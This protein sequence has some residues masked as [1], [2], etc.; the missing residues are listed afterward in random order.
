MQKK[1]LVVCQ[2]Y[3][4]ENFRI[5]D[6]I[7]GFTERGYSVDV[8]CG[9]PN[10]PT[11]QFFPGYDSHSIKEEMHNGVKVYRTFEIKRG[12]NSNIRIFLNY[13][14]FPVA[15]LLRSGKLKKNNYDKIFIYELSPVMM[16][17]AGLSLGRKMGIETTMYVLDI[18]PQNLYSVIDFKSTF[19]RKM[20]YKNS[21]WHYRK[22]DRLITVS[23]TAK[24]YFIEKLNLDE[25]RVTYIP[26]CPEKIYEEEIMDPDLV[27]KF[28]GGFNIIFAG[29]LSPAQSL[30]TI[31]DV[32][33]MVKNSPMKDVRFI[34]VGDGMSTQ[35][36]RKNVEEAGL[37]DIFF[38]EGFHPIEDIPKYTYIADALLGT[39]KVNGLQ[40]YSIPAKVMSYLAAGRPILLSMGGEAKK[41]VEESGGGLT[42]A[43]EDAEGIFRNIEKLYAMTR[44]ERLEM[45]KNAKAYQQEHF[46]RNKNVDRILDVIFGKYVKAE[47]KTDTDR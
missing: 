29:N 42:S 41:I 46:E 24:E 27:K 28:P 8:L 45:G 5:N 19:I 30:D 44:E 12:N 23:D 10:Y 43:P 16:S 32:A 26:Q 6:L 15:S 21:M 4:P 47:K 18:W 2:H 1:I 31:V 33:I 35:D 13:M 11:G 9:Q 34:I 14:T 40:D 22:A 39:L 36:F 25:S 20:L 37:N 17:I 38:F 3:W 7:D